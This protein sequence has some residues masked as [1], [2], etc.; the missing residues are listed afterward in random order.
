[1]WVALAGLWAC[2]GVFAWLMSLFAFGASPLAGDTVTA[3]AALVTG[4][5]IALRVPILTEACER[6][7]QQPNELV[8]HVVLL[9]CYAANINWLGHLLLRSGSVFEALPAVL[10]LLSAELWMHHQFF[11]NRCLSWL[12][13]AWWSGKQRTAQALAHVRPPG[14]SSARSTA[15]SKPEVPQAPPSKTAND[16]PSSEPTSQA[17]SKAVHPHLSGSANTRHCSEGRDEQGRRYMTGQL[18]LHFASGQSTQEIVIG[19]CPAFDGAPQVDVEA[20]D[21]DVELR[22]TACSPQGLR[23]VARRLR[24]ETPLDASLE[25][26]AFQADGDSAQREPSQSHSLP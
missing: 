11:S 16:T 9:L 20:S 26:Y 17:E 22:Q 12:K 14:T 7:R 5:G 6:D 10:L 25:W 3:L 2:S 13:L 15:A 18:V 19:F 23:L 8:D 21:G 24:A 4:V 1:M